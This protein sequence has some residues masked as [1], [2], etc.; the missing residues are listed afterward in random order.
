MVFDVTNG[1]SFESLK[2]W[3]QIVAEHMPDQQFQGKYF[4][5][6]RIKTY[7]KVW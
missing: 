5:C 1:A 3:I 6:V 7:L 2:D 4:C